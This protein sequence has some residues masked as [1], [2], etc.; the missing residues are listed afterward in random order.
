MDKDRLLS[1]D[2]VGLN[3]TNGQQLQ[4]HI[5]YMNVGDTLNQK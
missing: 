2:S 1:R 4:T 3:S 5:T